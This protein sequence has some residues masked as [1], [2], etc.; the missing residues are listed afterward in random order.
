M[1]HTVRLLNSLYTVAALALVLLVAA[2]SDDDS[3]VDNGVTITGVPATASVDNLGTATLSIALSAADG[4]ASFSV[5][6]DGAA[7]G[8]DVTYTNGETTAT[9]DF[10]YTAV[11]ADAN[12]N[13]TFVFTVTDADGDTETATHVLSVGAAPE[14]VTKAGSISADETWTNDRIYILA[15]RVVVGAGVTLTIEPGTIIKGE[16]GEGS[17]ASAL[18]VARGGMIDADGTASQPIIFTSIDDNIEVGQTAGTNLDE[19]D[20]GLWG[21]LIIL[22]NA[23]ISAD[24]ATV[25]I[26]GIP[27]D[28]AFGQYGGSD[29]ADNSGTLNY[30]SIRHGGSLIGEGN[31]INGLTLGGVGSGTVISN[32]EVVANQDDGIE[33]FGGTVNITNALV[34]AQGDDAY[35][36][37]QAYSGTI[38]N[39]IYIAGAG[40]DHG[41]E[42]DGPEGTATGRFTMTN[43]TMKGL[44]AEYADFRDGAMGTVTDTYFF[45][46]ASGSDFEIDADGSTDPNDPDD[47]LSDNPA[48][49]DNYANDL[50]VFT[51]LEFSE[52][53]NDSSTPTTL[54]ALFKDKW[55]LSPSGNGFDPSD[56]RTDADAVAQA[57]ANE[58]KF[59]NDNAIVASGASATVGADASVFE[60]TY[61][62]SQGQLADF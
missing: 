5:T 32:I 15:G 9:V 2:C 8:T 18:I 57:A 16:A 22:G 6:K 34:W 54:A 40:S 10:S 37:D 21:G 7:H 46:F 25:Q 56:T 26:E 47:K 60:W 29:A 61:A 55:E 23:P 20:D 33:C 53:V 14:P 28:D 41:L 12:S 39:F 1:K 11:E 44:S 30:I 31:E 49:S 35:D 19:T 4:L 17:L 36:I 48:G 24:A 27:A 45:N 3:T 51:G 58:T 42:I 52:V 13:I 62:A 50:L 43:G 59:I 38:D